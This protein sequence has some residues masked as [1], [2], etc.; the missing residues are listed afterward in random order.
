MD[1]SASASAQTARLLAIQRSAQRRDGPPPARLRIARLRQLE[2]MVRQRAEAF[3]RAISDD[4]GRRSEFETSLLE[5]AVLLSAL[6]HTRRHVTWWMQ[7]A[8]AEVSF[9]FWPG[10]AFVRSEPLGVV[11]ILAPWN[12]PLQL[13][14]APLIDAIAAGNRAIIKPSE[15]TPRFSALLKEAVSDTFSEDV[16]AVVLGGP[17]VAADFSSQPFDHLI[18]TGST[19]VGRRVAAAAAQ[20]LT[21]TT[22]ELGGK[23]PALICPSASLA[24]AA[25]TVAMGKFINAGQTCIAPDY[26][27]VPRQNAMAFCEAVMAEAGR[28][29]P[30]DSPDYSSLISAGAFDRMT[31]AVGQAVAAGARV[32]N[33]GQ[34]PDRSQRLFPPVIVIDPPASCGLLQEEI[35]A[36]VLP[37]ISYDTLEEAVG[38]IGDRPHPL[39]LYVFA[40]DRREESYVLDRTQSGGVTVN[41]TL[42]HVAQEGL[43]FG[44]VGASGWGAYHGKAGFDRLSHKRAVFRAGFI[45][46]A[47]WL[48]PPYGARARRLL[49]FLLR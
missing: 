7:P 8:Y 12:Y 24:K 33:H 32:L 47:S 23:S 31:E 11:G 1:G 45:N 42:L 15:H 16:V 29:Y 48:A 5:V 30:P 40:E 26:V 41:A 2:V 39:A 38:W 20:N 10:S 28:L 22:L 34:A 25:K 6:R 21:P 18:F 46:T 4:F 35:F 44:G 14:L 37:V 3:A 17:D 49:R 36:P 9:N 13:S 19:A 43:P 27:L